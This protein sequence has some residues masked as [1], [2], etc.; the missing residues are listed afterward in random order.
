[1]A[2]QKNKPSPLDQLPRKTPSASP[3]PPP[4]P[5]AEIPA[6][7]P[8]KE[9]T[10][11]S[12]KLV[13]GYSYRFGPPFWT[14]ASILSLVIN[15]ALIVILLV[16][17]MNTQRLIQSIGGAMNMGN[18]LLG[19]LYTNFEKMDRA[20]ITTNVSV[21]TEIPVK[22]DLQL[23][24]QTNVVLSQDVTIPNA[25]VTVRTGGMNITN[26]PTTIVLPQGTS[27]PVVLNL[28]VPVDKMVPVTLNVPVD[29]PLKDTQLHEPFVGLQDVVKPFY[30]MLNPGALN[31]DGQPVCR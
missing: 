1:M 29:I 7:Q 5:R 31:Q 16:V 6:D 4:Q 9:K 19:G 27:L 18:Y 26:A 12:S 8:R 10:S 28:T 17:W 15:L 14:I 13:I 20:H 11:P 24:Q 30:C 22:F 3:L 2:N 21:Q 23:N 25:L